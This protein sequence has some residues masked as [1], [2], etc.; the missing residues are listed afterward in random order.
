[1]RDRRRDLPAHCAGW[2]ALVVWGMPLRGL[3]W[4]RGRFRRRAGPDARCRGSKPRFG[5]GDAA[6]AAT[7]GV[8]R[9]IAA[10][11]R[12]AGFSLQ[13]VV[14]VIRVESEGDPTRSRRRARSA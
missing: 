6:R 5:A 14:A 1:M 11:A 8:A 10:E 3:G 13:F 2:F 12:R 7:A 4:V 9:T